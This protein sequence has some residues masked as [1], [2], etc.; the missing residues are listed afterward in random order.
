MGMIKRVKW[1][2]LDGG[3]RYI[4]IYIYAFFKEGGCLFEKRTE[5]IHSRSECTGK[6]ICVCL[7]SA[8]EI[9]DDH[10]IY[11]QMEYFD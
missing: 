4:Y 5:N 10:P 2:G 11:F 3:R 8:V 6:N 1:V 9:L 7:F